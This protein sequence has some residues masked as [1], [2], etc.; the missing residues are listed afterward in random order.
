[1]YSLPLPLLLQ[2]LILSLM[3]T[4]LYSPATAV[5]ITSLLLFPNPIWTSA[6]LAYKT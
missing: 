4:V 1:M 2:H 6:K 3:V 5:T